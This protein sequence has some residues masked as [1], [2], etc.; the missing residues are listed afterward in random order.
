VKKPHSQLCG[1]FTKRLLCEFRFTIY[2]FPEKR[3]ENAFPGNLRFCANCFA[4]PVHLFTKENRKTEFTLCAPALDN[5]PDTA[6][7]LLF[8]ADL[9]PALR[10]S[11]VKDGQVRVT[12]RQFVHKLL[13]V[14]AQTPEIAF[15]NDPV[16]FLAEADIKRRTGANHNVSISPLA[17][18]PTH[19]P[20]LDRVAQ[21]FQGA[22]DGGQ[23]P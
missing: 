1:F 14:N 21:V 9:L 18:K 2:V 8:L 20:G 6:V 15:H 10:G 23:I 5:Q 13:A 22:L 3:F 16:A 11:L 12:L 4:Q 19:L 17:A 7:F